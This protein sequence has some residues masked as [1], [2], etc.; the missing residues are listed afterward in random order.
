MLMWSFGALK[1]GCMGCCLCLSLSLSL[2]LSVL[3]VHS[4]E[5]LQGMCMFDACI[6]VHMFSKYMC[7]TQR[8][9]GVF[10]SCLLVRNAYI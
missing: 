9:A 6:S 3:G 4:D 2:S 8:A 10:G 1:K 7:A 5:Y